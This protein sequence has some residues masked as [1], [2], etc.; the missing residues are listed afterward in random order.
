MMSCCEGTR[1]IPIIRICG[2]SPISVVTRC[3]AFS[4]RS[5]RSTRII[6]GFNLR[7]CCRV[8]RFPAEDA[9]T[10]RSGCALKRSLMPSRRMR[11]SSI[12]RSVMIFTTVT[13]S[14]LL[15]QHCME[16]DIIRVVTRDRILHSLRVADFSMHGF[17]RMYSR[18]QLPRPMACANSRAWRRSLPR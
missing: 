13:L 15:V 18:G 16:E 3:K 8:S 9:T 17:C 6:R 10:R 7:T 11:L 1:P 5:P 4:L 2:N 14:T 12:R